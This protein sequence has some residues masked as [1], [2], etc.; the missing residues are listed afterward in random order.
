M[1]Q[2]LHELATGDLPISTAVNLREMGGYA[3]PAVLYIDDLSVYA[4]I[5][6]SYIKIPS[7][8]G[9]LMHVQYIRVL[10]DNHILKAIAWTDTRDMCA[11][12]TT[13][14]SVERDLLHACMDGLSKITHEMKIGSPR[15][16]YLVL[17][18]LEST[19]RVLV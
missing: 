7:G 14:G 2:L 16:N 15:V 8:N 5:T 17:N 4:A 19:P 11:D 13:K 1:C 6:A 10:L 9:T 18:S 12:G 3:V